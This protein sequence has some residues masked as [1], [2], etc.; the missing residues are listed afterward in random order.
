MVRLDS[1][2]KAQDTSHRCMARRRALPT[3]QKGRRESNE[4]AAADFEW[5][6][7]V[8]GFGRLFSSYLPIPMSQRGARRCHEISSSLHERLLGAPSTIVINGALSD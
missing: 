8:R 4:T 7:R 5:R 6:N 2:G 1:V 3:T